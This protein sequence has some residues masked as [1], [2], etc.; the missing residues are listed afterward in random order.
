MTDVFAL[1]GTLLLLGDLGFVTASLGNV[2]SSRL[3]V[4]PSPPWG[5]V[6]VEPHVRTALNVTGPSRHE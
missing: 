2:A 1:D 3:V 4:H 5:S 6:R